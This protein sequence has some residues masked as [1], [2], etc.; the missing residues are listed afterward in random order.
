MVKQFRLDKDLAEQLK[1]TATLVGKT[2]SLFIREAI[3]E[4]INKYVTA[5]YHLINL[6]SKYQMTAEDIERLIRAVEKIRR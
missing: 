4:Y 5:E 6:I 3:L 2:E 1:E